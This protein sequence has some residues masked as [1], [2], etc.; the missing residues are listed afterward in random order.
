MLNS[1]LHILN[2]SP[3]LVIYFTNIT[4]SFVGFCFLF[5]AFLELKFLI[6]VKPGVLDV[7]SF[8]LCAF[9][10]LFKK[11]FL[12]WGRNDILLYYLLK[13]FQ[14]CLSRLGLIHHELIFV[15]CE[16]GIKFHFIHMDNILLAS[17]IIWS[18]I[19]CC[20]LCHIPTVQI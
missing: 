19:T 15:C 11:L 13:A 3:L 2:S 5:M 4:S 14:F 6:L 8:M 12:P 10:V 17:F 20:Y 1:S 18:L 16:R 7:S 9:C